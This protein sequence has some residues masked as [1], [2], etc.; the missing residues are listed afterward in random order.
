MPVALWTNKELRHHIGAPQ[1]LAQRNE[2][3]KH[4]LKIV[5]CHEKHLQ[6]LKSSEQA[7][8]TSGAPAV[9][10]NHHG[11]W[12]DLGKIKLKDNVK[13]PFKA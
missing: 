2:A 12:R 3:D 5:W 9:G 4:R 13:L 6:A 7:V 11:R 1:Q 8:A 10:Q